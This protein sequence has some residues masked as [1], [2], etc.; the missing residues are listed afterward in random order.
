MPSDA[1]KRRA[2]CHRAATRRTAR[3]KGNRSGRT[4]QACGPGR[5]GRR[6]SRRPG[7]PGPRRA[8][9]AAVAPIQVPMVLDL[10]GPERLGEQFGQGGAGGQREQA[11]F[12]PVEHPAEEGRQ[13]DQ[14]GAGA[15]ERDAALC[16]IRCLLRQ[17]RDGRFL[18]GFPILS[19]AVAE[20]EPALRGDVAADVEVHH[21]AGMLEVVG[22]LEVERERRRSLRAAPAPCA[23]S[24]VAVRCRRR[25]SGPAP[26]S[27]TLQPPSFFSS[28]V[29]P[30]ASIVRLTM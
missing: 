11:Q 23:G 28:Q 8:A 20:L 25:G 19:R 26:P 7:R 6:A 16:R 14:P 2:S 29:V 5:F 10:L 27:S 21:V 1:R 22:P 13:Q 18:I 3:R 12:Q 4:R 9:R 15:C 17:G 30:S 24:P